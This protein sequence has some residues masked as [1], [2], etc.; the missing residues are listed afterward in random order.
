MGNFRLSPASSLIQSV[1]FAGLLDAQN[2]LSTDSGISR[3]TEGNSSGDHLSSESVRVTL[4]SM[5][6]AFIVLCSVSLW[7]VWVNVQS[8][9]ALNTRYIR[10]MSWS[11]IL[12]FSPYIKLIETPSIVHTWK[13]SRIYCFFYPPSHLIFLIIFK[14][15][16]VKKIRYKQPN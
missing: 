9:C 10:N 7:L 12:V 11:R 16:A 8:A 4:S 14:R 13:W 2:I 1:H 3:Q 5:T 6:E 15:F